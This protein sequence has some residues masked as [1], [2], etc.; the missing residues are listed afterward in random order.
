MY[1][2]SKIVSTFFGIG[3][4]PIASGTFGSLAGIF[5][6]FILINYFSYNLFVIFS[7][8]ILLLGLICTHIYLKSA[9][10]KDPSEVVVDEVIGQSIPLLIFSSNSN[11]TYII[12]AFFI[13]RFFD[14]FKIYPINISENLPG[15]FGV[16]A[17]D[18]I[19]GTYTLIIML[20]IV[21]LTH[22]FN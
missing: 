15:T 11:I 21:N 6:W 4:F 1:N 14:I 16:I 13:F 10:S 17:D 5:I 12:L 22:Y 19:A 8:L 18:I 3:Y 9:K 2:I 20:C 7:I